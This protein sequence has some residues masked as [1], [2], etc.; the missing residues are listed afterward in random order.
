MKN[1]NNGM[2]WWYLRQ[3]FQSAATSSLADRGLAKLGRITGVRSA[4]VT[5]YVAPLGRVSKAQVVK[6][7]M[8]SKSQKLLKKR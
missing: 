8:L 6:G 7:P 4:P 5:A 1:T 3:R 2:V